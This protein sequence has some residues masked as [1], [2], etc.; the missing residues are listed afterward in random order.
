MGQYDATHNEYTK[1]YNKEKYRRV[2]VYFLPEDKQKLANY[3]MQNGVTM[4]SYIKDVVLN[5]LPK[6]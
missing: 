4:G 6:S 2:Q 1:K 5:S 3:C